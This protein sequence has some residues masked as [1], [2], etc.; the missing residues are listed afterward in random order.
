MAFPFCFSFW[1]KR[2]RSQTAGAH[3]GA[4]LPARFI[5]GCCG[6]ILAPSRRK[7]SEAG[8]QRDGDATG[9]AAGAAV[10]RGRRLRP[11]SDPFPH[12]LR[13]PARAGGEAAAAAPARRALGPWRRNTL[14]L[15]VPRMSPPWR[16]ERGR[17]EVRAAPHGQPRAGVKAPPP[18]CQSRCGLVSTLP[19]PPKPHCGGEWPLSLPSPVRSLK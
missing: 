14:S 16:A 5:L 13:G 7:T 11:A 8:P 9:R 1:L 4:R 10:P 2:G 6:C 18:G 12:L 19:V 3:L 15:A 17:A